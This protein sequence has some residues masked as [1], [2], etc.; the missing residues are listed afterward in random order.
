MLNSGTAVLIFQVAPSLAKLLLHMQ[1]WLSTDVIARY[2]Q[3][4]SKLLRDSRL[5]PTNVVQVYA[6]LMLLS[7]IF[8]LCVW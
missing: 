5:A 7:H 8:V 4:S 1:K 6:A 3:D 2:R